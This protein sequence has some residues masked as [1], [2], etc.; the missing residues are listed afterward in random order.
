MR[1][2][3]VLVVCGAGFLLLVTIAEEPFSPSASGIIDYWS[4]TDSDLSRFLL[5]TCAE[6]MQSPDWLVNPSNASKWGMRA[7][8]IACRIA[9]LIPIHPALSGWWR[10]WK[11][12]LP[13]GLGVGMKLKCTQIEVDCS[14]PVSWLS[15]PALRTVCDGESSFKDFDPTLRHFVINRKLNL[16][17]TLVSR[18]NHFSVNCVWLMEN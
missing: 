9:Q 10:N 3:P 12:T 1:I 15:Y 5:A 7:P 8:S 14:D 2:S 6:I 4:T 16:G 18:R 13:R 17:C 11:I